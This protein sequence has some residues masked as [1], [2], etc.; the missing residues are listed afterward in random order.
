MRLVIVSGTSGAGKTIA[1][2]VLEDMGFYCIDNLPIALLPSFVI[3]LNA[4]AGRG[5]GDAAVG[6]DAR[7]LVG[8][9]S[10]FGAIL[11]NIKSQGFSCE[12]I[13]LDADTA[14][15]LKR[16]SETRRRHPLTKKGTSL[17]E[18]I[19]AERRLLKPIAERADWHVDT[20]RTT[21]HQLRDLIRTRMTALTESGLSLMFLSFG[22]K[23]GVPSDADTLF[24]V[25]CLPNPHWDPSLRTKTGREQEVIDFLSSQPAVEK[26]CQDIGDFVARW[27]PAY[28]QEN[29]SYMTVA[30]GCTGGQHRSV[31][32]IEQLAARFSS[33]RTNVVV[34][35]RELP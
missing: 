34:R 3:Q 5:Y 17:R 19:E 29:R 30:V 16:F 9:F 7:N 15:L 14:S 8:D 32:V 35:H 27:L 31:Y 22:F 20:T 33:A 13:F 2:Q 23:Y 24:D 10:E 12:L 4:A 6:I 18:A 26:M 21:I 25:R 11:E 28:E 1:L